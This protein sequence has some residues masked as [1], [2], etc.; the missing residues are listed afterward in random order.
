[1]TILAAIF[2]MM[3]VFITGKSIGATIHA[4]G[5]LSNLGWTLAGIL[6]AVTY[7][8]MAHAS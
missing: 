2:L 5:D 7:L 8:L 1:M 3:S 6:W 4:T